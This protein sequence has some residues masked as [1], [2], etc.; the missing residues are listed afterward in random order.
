MECNLLRK[1]RK[2]FRI[3]YVNGQWEI[4][5]YKRKTFKYYKRTDMA[6]LNMCSTFMS[7]TQLFGS[8]Y[9]DKVYLRDWDK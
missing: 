4:Y 6:I 1:L 5:D 3:L 9:S 7:I 2:K 8:K